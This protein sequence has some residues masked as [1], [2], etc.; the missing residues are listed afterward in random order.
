MQPLSNIDHPYLNMTTIGLASALMLSSSI[1][2]FVSYTKIGDATGLGNIKALL[3]SVALLSLLSSILLGIGV[4][5]VYRQGSAFKGFFGI[6]V[7]I[8]SV[9][10]MFISGIFYSIVAVRLR[11]NDTFTTSRKTAITSAV[12]SFSGLAIVGT[13][14]LI[15]HL[16]RKP[17]TIQTRAQTLVEQKP[18]YTDLRGASL[19]L[20]Q[21]QTA[22]SI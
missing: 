12:M 11:G 4:F 16:S 13:T 9:L 21:L 15:G 2:G 6:S 7:L 3:S 20:S 1:S 22:A 17:S 10:F 19:Q 14:F 8:L 18:A 5:L